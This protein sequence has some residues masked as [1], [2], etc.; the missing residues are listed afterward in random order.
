MT[1]TA[2]APAR[3]ATALA[4]RYAIDRQIGAGGMATVY[5][6][7]DLRHDREVALKVLRPEIGAAL[8][9]GRFLQ[10]IKISAQLDHPRILTL[11]DS[12]ETEG[13]V[14]Y[15][16]PYVR[17]ESLRQK[18]DREK[19]LSIE[20]ATKIA[21]QVA[22]ALDYAHRRGV[23]HRDIK[24]ENILL[25]E[26]EAVVADFGIALALKEAGGERITE[27]GLS[28]GTPQY[29]SPEQ[30]T[31]GRE[32]DA[33]SDLYSLAAVVY[34]MLAGEPPHSGPTVQAIIAKLMTERPTRIRTVRETVPEGIDAAVAKAL[35]KVP[36]DRYANAGEFAAALTAPP[37]SPVS[38]R[39][40][41]SLVV[42]AGLTGAAALVL[43]LWLWHPWRRGSK[44]PAAAGDVASVAVLPFDNL[45][46]N[47]ND[48][49]LSEGMTEEIIGQLAQMK[50]LKVISRTS[51]EALKDTRLTLRQIA[52]TLGVRHILEGSVRH[53][54]NRIRVAVDL[55]DATTDAHLWAAS[56]DRDL[57][58]VF[59]VQ[60]DI[61]RNVADS[62]GGLV[63]LRPAAARVSRT[64]SPAAYEAYISGRYLMYR[65]TRDGLR[66]A[67]EQFKQAIAK[68]STYAPAHADLAS[69]YVL[70]IIYSYGG[71]DL[72][73]V[74]GQ[75]MASADRAIALDSTSAEAYASRGLM[76]NISWAPTKEVAPDFERA[77]ELRPNSADIHQWYSGLLI[78]DGHYDEGMAEVERAVSLDPLAPGV[79][80]AAAA[81][82][83]GARRYAL[84]QQNA[85]R[86][87]T[88]E[89]GLMLAQWQRAL[90]ALLLGHPEQCV[91]LD[92]GPYTGARAMCLHSIG[93]TREAA[94][95][96][97]SLRTSFTSGA[98]G[99]STFSRITTARS[100]AEYYAWTGNPTE[101]LAW[102]EKGFALSPYGDDD[103]V[104]SSG[105]YDKAL[106]DAG[107][108]AGLARLQSRAYEKVRQASLKAAAR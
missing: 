60:E 52:D 38:G 29:M 69:S 100:L 92:L 30:A 58:D 32:L 67:M 34:E 31:G 20:E 10:E 101:S 82:A 68:D 108:K 11:I 53:A 15:V 66:G 79:R 98:L 77:L 97:D 42:A 14:W 12:G 70:W 65:R 26:G 28:L 93:K 17:G 94:Q 9:A 43:A 3:L 95:V 13:F 56:Y 61:A 54:A 51:T 49:Y 5:L 74:A 81:G 6:A 36:A 91:N 44:P 41:G 76:K 27:T 35:A 59:A 86:A 106:K 84:A 50:G 40:R 90:A 88:L 73:E 57:T 83:L 55:I 64:E 45:S 19:Q 48:R 78:R 8:G 104:L 87:A 72:Y 96:A 1:D 80:T 47:P 105:L 21:T 103:R 24:P 2:P 63:G 25:H 85:G 37:A 7:R 62:L 46:G 71:L 23:V 33:R 16:L 89:P 4:D 18:L 107:F 102:L 39:R 75:A 99:D 22:S